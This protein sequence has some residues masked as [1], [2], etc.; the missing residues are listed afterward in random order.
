M[1]ILN[2]EFVQIPHLLLTAIVVFFSIVSLYYLLKME[3]IYIYIDQDKL[4][5]KS[6][7][8]LFAKE[9]H[10]QDLQYYTAI[11]KNGKYL[12]WEDFDLVFPNDKVRIS[13]SNFSTSQYVALKNAIT[14]YAKKIIRIKRQ[15][16]E[17]GNLSI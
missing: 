5:I 9:F 6:F 12:S 2:H 1:P 3:V 10:L 15:N 14:P 4:T 17:A 13:S 7:Y 16:W 8:G 11:R